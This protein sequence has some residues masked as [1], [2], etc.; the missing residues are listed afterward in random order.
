MRDPYEI[1]GTDHDASAETLQKAYRKLAKKLHPDLNP[2]NAEAEEKFKEVASAYDLLSDAEKRGKFDAGEIDASGAVRPP[3]DYYRD[4]A[5]SSGDHPYRDDSAFADFLNSGSAFSDI[6]R[7]SARTHANRRGDDIGFRLPI[8]FVDAIVGA[9][10][11]INITGGDT[12]DVTIPPGVIEGQLL[13]LRG[14]GAPGSGEGGFG[15]ALVEIEIKPHPTFRREG[16]NILLDLPVNLKDAVLGARIQVHTPSGDVTMAVPKWSNTGTKLRL[17]GKGAPKA[18]GGHGDQL[19]TLKIM[20]PK[21][22]DP[23]LEAFVSGWEM[24]GPHNPGEDV[25]V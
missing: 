11:R 12:L 10:K 17:K 19:V 21:E 13:R 4:F 23:A 22:P 2:G 14:K 7:R 3:Q 16:D 5:A 1:L 25:P 9:N 24:A 20:L 8:E 6:L 18:S 15:D